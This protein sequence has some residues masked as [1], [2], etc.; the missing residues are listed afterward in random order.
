MKRTGISLSVVTLSSLMVVTTSCA[1]DLLK[2]TRE[3]I[4][5]GVKIGGSAALLVKG[6]TFVANNVTKKMDPTCPLVAVIQNA[7]VPLA[8][9]LVVKNVDKIVTPEEIKKTSLQSQAIQTVA[10]L[11]S[12]VISVKG[13]E[14]LLSMLPQGS[15]K[16]I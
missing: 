3:D 10:T 7:P 9:L 2:Q 16:T 8:T 15:Q 6:G 5:T 14:Y 4:W 13:I 11:T 12:Y 1:N